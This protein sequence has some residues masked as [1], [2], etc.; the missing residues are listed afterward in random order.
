[1]ECSDG[2]N[3]SVLWG[4]TTSRGNQGV[5]FDQGLFRADCEGFDVSFD[6]SKAITKLNFTSCDG[7]VVGANAFPSLPRTASLR[8]PDEMQVVGLF[9]TVEAKSYG[10]LKVGLYCM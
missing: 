9:G 1:V 8:C 7:G 5:A 2:S 4:T 6:N 10:L 3:S